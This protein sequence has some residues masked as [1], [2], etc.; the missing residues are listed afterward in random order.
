[1]LPAAGYR[2]RGLAHCR[3]HRRWAG[4]SRRPQASRSQVPGRRAFPAASRR[5]MMTTPD[6]R[7]FPYRWGAQFSRV[8]EARFRIWAPALDRLDL[9]LAGK[10]APMTRSED[11][12]FELVANGVE[13]G[14][15]YFFRLPD[16]STVPDPAARAQAGD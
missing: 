10:T 6:S 9:V 4:R 2:R 11:G 14:Q 12:W 7:V 1:R 3:R 5:R 8:G 13:H 16:G 15:E